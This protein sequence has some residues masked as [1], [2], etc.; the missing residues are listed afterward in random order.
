M[1]S[2]IDQFPSFLRRMSH[3]V[4]RKHDKE[5]EIAITSQPLDSLPEPETAAAAAGVERESENPDDDHQ[6]KLPE[7]IKK[8][9]EEANKATPSRREIIDDDDDDD[10]FKTP[11]SSAHRIPAIT[12]CPPPPVKPRPPPSKLKR[13]ASPPEVD[14]LFPPIESDQGDNSQQHKIKKARTEDKDRSS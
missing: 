7:E 1:C 5:E 4:D 9:E 8:E 10:G 12:E 6:K 14:S 3:P 2:E 13:K 11:T